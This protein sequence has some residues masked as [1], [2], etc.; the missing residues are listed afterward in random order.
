MKYAKIGSIGAFGETPAELAESFAFTLRLFAS[1][2]LDSMRK[3]W[4]C[5][6]YVLI[7]CRPSPEITKYS[8]FKSLLYHSVTRIQAR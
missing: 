6:R 8:G 2:D 5:S 7:S 1:R 4:L 3:K